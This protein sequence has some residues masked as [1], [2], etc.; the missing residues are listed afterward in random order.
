MLICLRNWKVSHGMVWYRIE[1]YLNYISKVFH[2]LCE[3]CMTQ[4]YYVIS[5]FMISFICRFYY[6]MWKVWGWWLCCVHHVIYFPPSKVKGLWIIL[7]R[8]NPYDFLDSY[9]RL[10][11]RSTCCKVDLVLLPLY[12][13]LSI[14]FNGWYM[15]NVV[16]LCMMNTCVSL[17]V[18]SC[19]DNA[20]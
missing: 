6:C 2:L 15:T 9:H 12:S 16:A 10:R 1:V 7:Q 20:E 14:T 5:I 4:L 11:I 3:V 17:M 18:W 19:V 13:N 8:F